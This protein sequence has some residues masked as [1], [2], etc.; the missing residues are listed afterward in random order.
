MN[1]SIFVI[2]CVLGGLLFVNLVCLFFISRKSQRVMRDLLEIMLHP[3]HAKIQHAS[4][5]LD[6]ILKD[7]IA[8][9]DANFKSMYETLNN[10]ISHTEEIKGNLTTQN[11]KLVDLAEESSKKITLMSQRLENTIGG[12]EMIVNSSQW[13][14]I[15]N[16]SENFNTK[17]EGLL[18]QLGKTSDSIE[19]KSNSIQTNINECI[20]S[21]KQLSEQLQKSFTETTDSMNTMKTSTLDLQNQLSELNTNVKS[22]FDTIKTSAS[23]YDETMRS[24]DKMLNSYLTKLSEFTKQHNKEMLANANALNETSNCI[25]SANLF[26]ESTLNKYKAKLDEMKVAFEEIA[27]S[28]DDKMKTA[29]KNLND[30]VIVFKKEI[31]DFSF[32]I[33]NQLK[34]V[35]GKL[36][37]TLEE[38]NSATTDYAN[39]VKSMGSSINDSMEKMKQVHVQLTA[40]ATDLISTSSN[41]TAQ[42]K[43]MS[44]LIEKYYQALPDLTRGSQEMETSIQNIVNTLVEKIELM[45]TTLA[46]SL[47]NMTES[48]VSLGKLSDESRQQMI[49]L[50]T[51]Y[52]KAVEAMQSLNNQMM[53]ARASA[54]MDAI[55]VAPS[56]P[57]KPISAKDFLSSIDS[58]LEK[59][60]AQS[61]DLT[62]ALGTE[63]PPVIWKKYQEGDTKIFA[64]WLVKVFN[65]TDSKQIR[66]MLKSDKVFNSQAVQ[67]TH[68][69]EKILNTAAKTDNV[70]KIKTTLLKSDL[71]IIY[72]TLHKN[73]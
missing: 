29:A 42:L 2:F 70:V 39:S 1:Q 4:R 38:T 22:E 3:E 34:E 12:L 18:N 7:E 48:S 49:D 72:N 36:K 28:T 37:S 66:T 19:E 13:T 26:Q 57:F 73:M 53:I 21:E 6:A 31:T 46:E 35:S 16:T 51:D 10:Q 59:L 5:V 47:T 61:V 17:V 56:E 63:I 20:D 14:N 60:Y 40:K 11:D 62:R 24:N 33:L 23:D 27:T 50:M 30:L 71:G 64:K 58:I 45:K 52:T 44:E 41:T 68:N 15:Q 67:F 9:I 43:P 32:D 69:F 54:P 25:A 55:K 8:K 65:A